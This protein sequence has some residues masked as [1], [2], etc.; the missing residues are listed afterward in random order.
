MKTGG[1]SSIREIS[2]G[3]WCNLQVVSHF[4]KGCNNVEQNPL[5]LHIVQIYLPPLPP[6]S[7][8]LPD[9]T[10]ETVFECPPPPLTLQPLPLQSRSFVK[11]LPVE[12]T[13]NP[14][15]SAQLIEQTK[16]P[17]YVNPPLVIDLN[18]SS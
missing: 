3:L 1:E 10:L 12:V 9:H 16:R 17:T 13:P 4:T 15:P 5:P 6:H 14:V 8:N 11:P 7:N 18:H 2:A